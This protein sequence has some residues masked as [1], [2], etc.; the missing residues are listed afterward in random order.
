MQAPALIAV[1]RGARYEYEFVNPRSQE[2]FPDR[3]LPGRPV[4]E[5]VPES[6]ERGFI[7][8]LDRVYQT[9]EAFVGREVLLQIHRRDSGQ[10][11]EVCLNFTYQAHREHSEIVGISCFAFNVTELVSARQQME[12]LLNPSSPA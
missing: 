6:M 1:V 4:A 8:L 7:E 9:G 5:A 12:Q 3:E 2:L 11:A 10:V